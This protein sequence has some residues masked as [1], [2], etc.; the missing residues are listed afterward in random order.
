MARHLTE[1]TIVEAVL[2]EAPAGAAEHAAGCP[3]CAGRLA[4][5]RAG[6]AL[7]EKVEVPE[8]SPLYWQAFRRNVGQRIEDDRRGTGRWWLPL[9]AA[10]AAA[11]AIVVPTLRNS[12]PPASESL[13]PA[14]S[15][16]PP[17][18]EDPGLEV[19]LSLAEGEMTDAVFQVA[20]GDRAMTESLADLSAEEA[21]ALERAL[22]P[23][24][25][26]GAL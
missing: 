5:A 10:A 6:L 24:L 8:P 2:G 1:E 18:E 11:L 23:H 25:E 9:A 19:I 22:G 16:L 15:A 17:A 4:E 3:S 14:W 20:A 13:L 26:E 21:A 7:A 12:A